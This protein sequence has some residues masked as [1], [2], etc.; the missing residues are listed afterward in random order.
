MSKIAPKIGLI[1]LAIGVIV[2]AYIN[3][4]HEMLSLDHLQSISASLKD[5]VDNNPLSSFFIAFGVMVF[6]YS[7]PLPAAALMSLTAGFVFNFEIGLL[8]VLSTSLIAATLTFLIA[9]Y[10]ARDWIAEKFAQYMQKFDQEMDSNGFFYALSLRMVPGIPFIA[11]N[12]SFGIT[13]LSLKAFVLSTIFGMAPISAI[14]VNAG[15][16]F[17]QIKSVSDVL[18]PQIFMSLLL[19]ASFPLIVRFLSN[20]LLNKKN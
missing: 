13:A 12:A 4:L 6:V 10:I 15:S 7:L 8:L 19:L 1:I 5:Y 11:L 14:L 2:I 18:T 9:R 20:K 17:N 16:Q 3:G